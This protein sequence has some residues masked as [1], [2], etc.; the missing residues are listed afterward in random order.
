[1]SSGILPS[2]FPMRRWGIFLGKGRRA[3]MLDIFALVA[4]VAAFA[5]AVGYA[6]LCERL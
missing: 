6:F 1:M 4:I 2:R 3:P 5:A